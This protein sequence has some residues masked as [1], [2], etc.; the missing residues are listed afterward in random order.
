MFLKN[1]ITSVWTGCIPPPLS[2][3]KYTHNTWLAQPGPWSIGQ[4]SHVFTSLYTRGNYPILTMCYINMIICNR[5]FV[6]WLFV[7][8]YSLFII[9]LFKMYYEAS[10]GHPFTCYRSSPPPSFYLKTTS[11]GFRGGSGN[12]SC[13]A[14]GGVQNWPCQNISRKYKARFLVWVC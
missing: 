9:L 3:A 11:L 14:M 8:P 1:T 13:M 12:F 2:R 7:I 10:L 5:L 6:I 4:A